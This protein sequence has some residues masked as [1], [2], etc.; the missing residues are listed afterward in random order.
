[1]RSAIDLLAALADRSA[2]NVVDQLAAK[3]PSRQKDLVS[4]LELSPVAVSRV[5]GRL[6]DEG[7][8]W[9][10]GRQSAYHLAAPAETRA[11]LDAAS[12]LRVELARL[13]LEEAHQER[14]GRRKAALAG[15][16]ARDQAE[17]S[18]S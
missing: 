15:G 13:E 18:S 8:V 3:G 7:L 16:H 17:S 14:R 6:E 1:M 2:A 5:L 11:L 9:R 4:D 10:E 12:D